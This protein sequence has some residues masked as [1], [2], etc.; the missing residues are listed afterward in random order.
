VTPLWMRRR[1]L[2][3]ALITSVVLVFLYLPIAAVLI[4]AFNKDST[5]ATWGGV[6]GKWF[7]Q[8]VSDPEIR[9]SF[10]QSTKIALATTAI[11]VAIAICAAL[12]WRS[13]GRWGRTLLDSTTFMR[14]ALPE[15]VTALALFVMFRR[16]NITLG[17]WTVIAGHV[18]FNS[19]YATIVVQA[20][21]A[22]LD[23]TLEDAAADLGAPPRRV[24]RRVVLPLLSPAVIVAALLTFTFSF[25]DVVTS[26]FLA[27]SGTVTL[28][29]EI[30]GLVR[31]RVTPEVNAI[32][33]G[34]MLVT[35]TGFTLAA[36]A[37]FA[38]GGLRRTIGRARA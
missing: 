34:V 6:T 11:S 12:Y 17:I 9:H 32:G 25:D 13:A 16:L 14:I 21:V 1:R 3:L 36:V 7:G 27:G 19:A 2:G 18:M 35:L 29:M 37:L 5:L 24:F 4:N 38:S 20:R 26:L 30:F 33:S 15:V 23:R 8:A 22:A 31:F 10:V 28:P